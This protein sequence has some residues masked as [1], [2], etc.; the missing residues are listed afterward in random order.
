MKFLFA[1][2][3]LVMAAPTW[4]AWPL[5]VKVISKQTQASQVFNGSGFL[6]QHQN[7][8][9]VLTSDHV[10]LHTNAGVHHQVTSD[11]VGAL[12]CQYLASD[13][14]AGLA[15]L[16][17]T[18]PVDFK[19]WPDL[20][21]IQIA[22][23]QTNLSV[24]LMGFPATSTTS[25]RDFD[26]HISNP[27]RPSSILADVKSM[28]EV[29]DG[30]AE[31]GMSGGLA[32]SENGNYL[33]TLS[34][35]IYSEDANHIQNLI[36]LIPASF[37][38]QWVRNYF[39]DS[40]S[41]RLMQT[42]AQQSWTRQ[43]AFSTGRLSILFVDT[44]SNGGHSF[45]IGLTAEKTKNL[46]AEDVGDL[47]KYQNFLQQNPKC[48]ML[49]KSFRRRNQFGGTHWF[50]SDVIEA[51]RGFQDSSRE[52][53]THLSCQQ[54]EASVAELAKIADQVQALNLPSDTSEFAPLKQ[55]L[56]EIGDLLHGA[57]SD[58]HDS[59]FRYEDL[60][61]KDID[62]LL[63]DPAYQKSWQALIKMGRETEVR[64]LLQ[65]LRETLQWV[66]I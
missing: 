56:D 2:L 38:L 24:I 17:V 18:S 58:P 53:I 63:K 26:G 36:L 45:N 28:I 12:D 48:S 60:K 29:Q 13:Y 11:E 35:Q 22:S 42:P 65:H 33:G 4:A 50:S 10:V 64:A 52:P 20:D 66:T 55:A 31:F 41:I 39:F 21:N 7:Q 43:P 5:L 9:Y 14:G 44:Y 46:Y 51:L 59:D 57:N 34:H 27:E 47:L 1:F 6:F 54:T 30:H 16:Q 40:S 15:L 32:L 37:S 62:V 25:V 61:P 8:G 49:I 3:I 19:T 23:P